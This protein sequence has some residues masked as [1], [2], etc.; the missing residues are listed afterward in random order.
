MCPVSHM[1]TS[2][3]SLGAG[4]H[5][6]F[7]GFV[8]YQKLISS[9]SFNWI[10][11]TDQ[12]KKKRTNSFRWCR[13]DPGSWETP[14]FDFS[15]NWLCY[16]CLPPYVCFM[17]ECVLDFTQ[18]MR[19]A[20]ADS[21][22]FPGPQFGVAGLA[23][24]GDTSWVEKVTSLMQELTSQSNAGVRHPP[25]SK[26]SNRISCFCLEPWMII[27]ICVPPGTI[28]FGNHPDLVAIWIAVF[29]VG[30]IVPPHPR[31]IC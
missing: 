10:L 11:F 24:W 18:Y 2:F 7:R 25:R 15:L 16:L 27:S 12:K 26:A 1:N 28:S 13:S 31:F 6:S 8:N 29:V 3:N 19:E 22:S 23:D 17:F 20:C 14:W 9:S 30:V 5:L 4:N 21:V